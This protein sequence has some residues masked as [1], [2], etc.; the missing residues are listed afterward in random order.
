MAPRTGHHLGP[1]RVDE[2]MG[3]IVPTAT[4]QP[5]QYVPVTT[6]LP[7]VAAEMVLHSALTT[8]GS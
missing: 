3:A 5:L 6:S 8:T 1:A 7:T 2:P 4:P